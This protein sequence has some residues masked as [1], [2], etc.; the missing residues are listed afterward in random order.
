MKTENKLAKVFK[1]LASQEHTLDSIAGR[2]LSIVK[3]VRG[4]N[5]EKFDA[6]VREAY[7][8]NGWNIRPGRPE[9][10]AEPRADVPSTVR[11]YVTVIRRSLRLGLKVAR[12]NSFSALRV[13]LVA[14]SVRMAANEDGDDE[15]GGR[16][17]AQ[18]SPRRI[19]TINGAS[20]LPKDVQESFVGVAIEKPK[21]VNGA[22][23]HDLAAVFIGLPD[24]H[25]D[26]LGRQLNKLL[27]KYRP[28]ATL[29]VP[30]APASAQL[31]KAA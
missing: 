4:L 18:T 9:N 12:Y 13:A 25:R 5:E 14:K 11:T 24:A 1:D 2:V 30:A 21:D 10:G 16:G 26:V 28:L 27:V 31:R 23:F 19:G 29:P 6:L 8:A 15:G 22:L 3:D 7:E 17:R 20:R